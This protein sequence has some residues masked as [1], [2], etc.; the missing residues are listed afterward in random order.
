MAY[1]PLRLEKNYL[2]ERGKT[3]LH[4]NVNFRSFT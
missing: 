3:I 1:S 4:W 2:A